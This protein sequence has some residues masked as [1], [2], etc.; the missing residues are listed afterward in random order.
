[1]KTD[2]HYTADGHWVRFM[3]NTDAG[4]AAWDELNKQDAA[5]IPQQWFSSVKAQLKAAGYTVRKAPK[6]TVSDEK[7]LADLLA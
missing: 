1:M 5:V 7:L 3:P 2:L 6:V 4:K